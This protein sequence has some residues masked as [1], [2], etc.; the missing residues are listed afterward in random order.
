MWGN[1]ILKT[2]NGGGAMTAK[3]FLVVSILVLAA[4]TQ[5]VRAADADGGA[6]AGVPTPIYRNDVD[7]SRATVPDGFTFAAGGDLFNRTP[8]SQLGHPELNK[9]LKLL[10]GADVTFANHESS[11]FDLPGPGTI[12][13][14][15]QNGGGYP[16]FPMAL[17]QDFKRMGIDMVSTANNH[18][19]DWGQEGITATL[20]AISAAGLVQAG[21]GA[22]LSDARKPGVFHTPRGSVG[23]I[24]TASTFNPAT[25]AADGSGAIKPRPGISVLRA[26]PVM[27]LTEEQMELM[28]RVSAAWWTPNSGVRDDEPGAVTVG[29]ATYRVGPGGKLTYQ[30]D[31]DDRKAVISSITNAKRAYDVVAFSIHA[32]EVATAGSRASAGDFLPELFH[33]AIDAGADI[34][35]RHGPHILG[36]V[37]IYKGKPIFYSLSSLFFTF[38]S[39]EN[40]NDA[41]YRARNGF[42]DNAVGVTEFK[43]GKPSVVRIYPLVTIGERNQAFG[44]SKIATGEDAR[45]I[46]ATIQRESQP[47]GTRISVENDIGVIRIA[48]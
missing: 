27:E 16:R 24:A 3:H 19:G 37:E 32:H 44:G 38:G 41:E 39:V 35:I 13:Y 18:A 14:A 29:G 17:E 30:V 12:T 8:L 28:R 36:G 33:Q 26:R 47:Y 9:M 7:L 48:Q 46:L 20:A 4:Q 25:M 22:S 31:Q 42:Y 1:W 21:A 15:A 6:A 45:R 10:Q 5:A 40:A 11:A 43:N 2:I 34:V 23:L